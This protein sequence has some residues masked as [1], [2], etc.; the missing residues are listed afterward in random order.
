MSDQRVRREIEEILGR[1]EEFVPEEPV[2]TRVRRRSSGVTSTFRRGLVAP[3]PR[4]SSRQVMLTALA[5]VVIAFIVMQVSPAFGRWVVIAGVAL[6]LGS[7]VFSFFSGR[8][9]STTEKRWRGRPM[10][11][12]EP[13]FGHRM[14][15]WLQTKRRPPR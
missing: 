15:S 6:F 10:E 8:K 2:A 9:S 11:L 7:F 4:I 5:L 3:L 13:S 1:L 14:R 12:D